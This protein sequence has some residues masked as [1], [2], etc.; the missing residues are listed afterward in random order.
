[1]G[2]TIAQSDHKIKR[3]RFKVKQTKLVTFRF[4]DGVFRRAKGNSSKTLEE[5][6]QKWQEVEPAND[7]QMSTLPQLLEEVQD[8]V[9]EYSSI[10]GRPGLRALLKLLQCRNR[11]IKE[12][13]MQGL[14]NRSFLL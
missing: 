1:M 12:T 9:C 6:L 11:G 14:H 5:I 7:L 10:G 4:I 3:F 2:L 8:A 13:G